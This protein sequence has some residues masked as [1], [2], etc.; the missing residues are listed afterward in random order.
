MLTL[1]KFEFYKIIRQKSVLLGLA[2]SFLV[3]FYFLNQ[4]VLPEDVSPLY[5]PW[6]GEVTEEKLETVIQKEK[7]L[8]E[9]PDLS[10]LDF[11]QQT[12]Y[13]EI[14]LLK[15][16]G[17]NRD[18][19]VTA[20]E[21]KMSKLDKDSYTYQSLELERDLL[22][23]VDYQNFYYKL[24]A[25]QMQYFLGTGGFIILAALILIALSPIYSDEANT[26]VYQQMLGSKHGR[27]TI[28]HAKIFASIWFVLLL[29]VLI[30]L[31]D[32]IFWSSA[33]GNEGWEAIIQTINSFQSSPYAFDLGAYFTIKAAY[34]FLSGCSLALFVNLVSS[35]SN[36]TIISFIVCTFLVGLQ[37]HLLT[38]FYELPSIVQT[39]LDFSHAAGMM[40]DTLF[41]TYKTYNILG[42]PV[43]YPIMYL[44][45]LTVVT[46]IFT[47]LNY[48]VIERKQF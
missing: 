9:E 39:L 11:K 5:K 28:V 16:Y 3:A 2:I 41:Q 34:L 15:E 14:M 29:T 40:T 44:I 24:P 20:L 37:A 18:A 21:E 26:G 17:Q 38:S 36:N 4:Q 8:S 48:K 25:E 7:Q 33:Y 46:S 42:Y 30:L 19:T 47:L 32:V 35:M 1:T 27:K 31:F 13:Q 43:L 22:K 23:E 45:V 10:W 6:E 12:V